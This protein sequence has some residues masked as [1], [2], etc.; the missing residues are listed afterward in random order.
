M[1][2][3]VFEGSLPE[4]GLDL[5]LAGFEPHGGVEHLSGGELM[6]RHPQWAPI[7]EVADGGLYLV[8]QHADDVACGGVGGVGGGLRGGALVGWWG[9]GWGIGGGR[10]YGYMVL[11]MMANGWRMRLCLSAAVKGQGMVALG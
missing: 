10:R 1:A 8:Q 4:V 2:G 7:F 11:D 9:G 3:G 6:E 5:L